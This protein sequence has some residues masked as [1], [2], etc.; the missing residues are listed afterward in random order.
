M[1]MLERNSGTEIGSPLPHAAFE[2]QQRRR[3]LI[4]L[5]VL[6]VALI[7]VLIKDRQFWFPSSPSAESETPEQIVPIRQP[8]PVP[9]KTV[10]RRPS[11]TRSTAH[12]TSVPKSKRPTATA[13][14]TDNAG[15]TV[16]SN[17]GD[18]PRR[19]PAA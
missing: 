19:T 1:P 2:Q 17:Y 8:A 16:A 12:P 3:M 15:A 11:E 10:A 7:S 6:L 18:E 14:S 4:A 9:V 5:I 13:P